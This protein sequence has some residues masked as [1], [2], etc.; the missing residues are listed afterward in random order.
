MRAPDGARP[1]ASVLRLP[2]NGLVMEFDYT[3]G[4]DGRLG[5]Y[6]SVA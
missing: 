6:D 5:S 3:K 1:A 4:T 2:K